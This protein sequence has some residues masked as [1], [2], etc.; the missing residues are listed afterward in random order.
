MWCYL[1]LKCHGRKGERGSQRS[2]PLGKIS[3]LCYLQ[4]VCHNEIEDGTDDGDRP[5]RLVATCL[6]ALCVM[7]KYGQVPR[8]GL[9]NA[10]H[11]MTPLVP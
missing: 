1:P 2:Q 7:G 3:V 10:S 11:L 8:G 4:W 6:T 5:A 9:G